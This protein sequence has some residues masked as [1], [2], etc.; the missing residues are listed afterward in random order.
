[1]VARHVVSLYRP[2]R[3]LAAFLDGGIIDAVHRLADRELHFLEAVDADD[4]DVTERVHDDQ[5]PVAVERRRLLVD[6]RRAERRRRS[7]R[8]AEEIGRA[9]CRERVWIEV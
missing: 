4:F 3:L 9:S 7:G 2:G 1:M 8:R 6:L 5:L